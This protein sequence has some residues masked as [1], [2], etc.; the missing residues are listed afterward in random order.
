MALC[1]AQPKDRSSFQRMAQVKG[2]YKDRFWHAAQ[3]A[4]ALPQSHLPASKDPDASKF[5]RHAIRRSSDSAQRLQ[6][7]RD[8]LT[9]TAKENSLPL[10]N[11]LTPSFLRRFV[12]EHPGKVNAAQAAQA[13][14]SYGARDWQVAL[15][16]P[17]IA[18]TPVTE[19]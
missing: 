16:A 15:S 7:L 14:S 8:A 1:L 2:T 18:A 10:E 6:D 13:L 3:A 19:T 9:V 4:Y 11:L 5:G 12:H 17:V